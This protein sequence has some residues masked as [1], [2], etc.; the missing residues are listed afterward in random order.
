M[1]GNHDPNKLT[2]ELK[3]SLKEILSNELNFNTTPVK[4]LESQ[5]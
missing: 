4:E 5:I 3:M 1:D 2:D